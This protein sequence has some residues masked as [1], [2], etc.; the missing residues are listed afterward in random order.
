MSACSH[1][2][3]FKSLGSVW[4]L[5]VQYF[6]FIAISVWVRDV[7]DIAASHQRVH[8]T[9]QI[10]EKRFKIM[11]NI[12]I[13]NDKYII[14]YNNIV[15]N[16]FIFSLNIWKC[17]LVMP[18]P[19]DQPKPLNQNPLMNKVQKNRFFPNDKFCIVTNVIAVT[20]LLLNETIY[21]FKKT[22]V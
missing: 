18:K 5:K 17:I 7:W 15:K 14:I 3:L 2:P 8:P 10:H 16:H 4:L 20:E 12:I 9:M 19:L 1:I 22:N 13:Y 11:I 21:F 6:E